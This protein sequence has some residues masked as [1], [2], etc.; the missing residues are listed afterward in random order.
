MNYVYHFRAGTGEDVL[1][2]LLANVVK[3]EHRRKVIN[4]ILEVR[5]IRKIISSYVEAQPDY[6]GRL[7]TAY[8]ICGAETGRSSASILEPALKT[9]YCW[10]RIPSI[11]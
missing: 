11:D 5:R 9:R 2:G 10:I 7:R 6:D 3:D 1:V 4:L 8:N